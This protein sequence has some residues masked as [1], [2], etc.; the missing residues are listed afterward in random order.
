MQVVKDNPT[1]SVE[2]ESRLCEEAGIDR[3]ARA[4][5]H[6]RSPFIEAEVT[7]ATF[8]LFLLNGR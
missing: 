5:K 2:D 8:D 6:K 7:E 3:S 4:V 1:S